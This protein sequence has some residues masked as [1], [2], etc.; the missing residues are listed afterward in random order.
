MLVSNERGSWRSAHR[1]FTAMVQQELPVSPHASIAA[2][3]ALW[4]AIRRDPDDL[5]A[6]R[7]FKTHAGKQRS[8]DTRIMG[9]GTQSSRWRISSQSGE[10]TA[11]VPPVCLSAAQSGMSSL[12]LARGALG[13]RNAAA[14][15]DAA[16]V[17]AG[18]SEGSRL[19]LDRNS[20]RSVKTSA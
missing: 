16:R 5:C 17:G 14:P 12:S 19:S 18:R 1:H 4:T 20:A 13:A 10:L 9:A 8:C 7:A 2:T 3:L 15:D 11:R 6:G